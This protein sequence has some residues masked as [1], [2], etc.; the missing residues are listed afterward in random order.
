M[1]IDIQQRFLLSFVNVW[2][3]DS[4]CAWRQIKDRCAPVGMPSFCVFIILVESNRKKK[5]GKIEDSKCKKFVLSLKGISIKNF[6]LNCTES[7]KN[8]A[9][10]ST[11]EVS[12]PNS[13]VRIRSSTPVM[14]P[15]AAAYPTAAVCSSALHHFPFADGALQFVSMCRWAVR[16]IA[17][18]F[19]RWWRSDTAGC[20]WPP[21]RRLQGAPADVPPTCPQL[22]CLT[23]CCY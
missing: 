4:R 9:G 14:R 20:P 6:H 11:R 8:N 12:T 23:L 2:G 19:A 7:T 18:S 13:R 17:C 10:F 15:L 22:C 5:W 16:L 3:L 21:R 1:K